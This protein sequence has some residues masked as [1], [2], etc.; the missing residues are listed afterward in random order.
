MNFGS[1]SGAVRRSSGAVRELC[2]SSSGS[3]SCTFATV[4]SSREGQESSRGTLRPI[5]A[6]SRST[7]GALQEHFRSTSEG[8]WEQSGTLWGHC[9]CTS[10]ALRVHFGSSRERSGSSQEHSG[11]IN[12]TS[13]AVRHTPGARVSTRGALREHFRSTSE[14]LREQ[15]VALR[16]GLGGASRALREQSRRRGICGS[17]GWGRGAAGALRERCGSGAGALRERRGER[18]GSALGALGAVGGASGVLRKSCGSASGALRVQ[19][20][21][22]G[23]ISGAGK[24]SQ[25]QFRS[26][27]GAVGNNL[28]AVGISLEA[29]REKLRAVRGQSVSSQA[30]SGAVWE[31][32]GAVR[33]RAAPQLLLSCSP[34]APPLLPHCFSTASHQPPFQGCCSPS[35]RALWRERPE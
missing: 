30:H 1:C 9:R 35:C 34:T 23:S 17:A 2:G 8:C 16:D 12:C 14:T 31:Q 4:G 3:A 26:S 24:N 28:M 19:T 22:V 11:T 18:C 21:S 5:R 27:L 32:P 7:A 25:E 29:V 20:G 15:S 13:G 6:R 33:P 10:K